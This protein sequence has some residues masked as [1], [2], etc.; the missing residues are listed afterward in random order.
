MTIT[1][2]PPG[3]PLNRWSPTVGDE[4]RALLK[5]IDLA[6]GSSESL[7]R[8]TKSIL[9]KCVPPAAVAERYTGIV[10]GYVQ[11]G[12]TLSFTTLTALARD[13]G[14]RIIVV[15]TG[16][17]ILLFQQS[18][19]RLARDLR[20]T[21]RRD[22]KWQPFAVPPQHPDMS[23]RISDTLDDWLDPITPDAARQTVLITVMKHHSRLDYLASVLRA[24]DLTAVPALIIDDE[25][26]QAGLN[27]AVSRGSQSS[28][29]RALVDLRACCPSHT[30]V[31]Y[32]A[33]P[34]APL[35]INLIDVLS[36]EFAEVISPGS[37]YLG[38]REFFFQHP[39]LV[40]GIP[41]SELPVRGQ[42]IAEPPNSLL[43][44]IRIYFLGVAAGMSEGA[45]GN[46]S[47]LIHPSRTTDFHVDFVEIV[48]AVKEQWRSVLALPPADPD[49][50]ELLEEF[51]S[52]YARL[53]STVGPSIPTF[54]DISIRLP[55][56]I[57]KTQV[58]EVNSREEGS[59]EIDWR[60]DYSWILVGGQSMDRGFT[61]EGLTVTYMPRS[62][63]TANA[64]TV[65]QRARF[66]GYKR[67]YLGY[68]RVYLE[69]V[70]LDAYKK[71]V[72]HEEDLRERLIE[73]TASGKPLSE[74]KRA[75]FLSQVL[76]P[77]R[78]NVMN[79]DYV[80][81]NLSDKWFRVEHP[82]QVPEAVDDN[83]RLV[84]QLAATL[85]FTPD[86]G[87]PQRTTHQQHSVASSV[88]LADLYEGFLTAYRVTEAD[89]SDRFTGARLQIAAYLDE[90]PSSICSVYLMSPNSVRDR[91]VDPRLQIVKLF[92]GEAPVEPRD[93]RGSVYP[94]DDKIRANTG[95]TMQIHRL[96]LFDG[97]GSPLAENV[98]VIALWIPSEMAAAWFV[99]RSP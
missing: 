16:T 67:P 60:R 83:R 99:Q 80:R 63:G 91:T 13:N 98:P 90:H 23:R 62:V 50:V 10:V 78:R 93:L 97:A 38:G 53:A 35:L 48:R 8:E 26:D 64:D 92:Q 32:T 34:Q 36:P 89:E 87:S 88:P 20:L 6:D 73:H 70:A 59:T 24:V 21:T 45:V 75:F 68:C 31:Q 76:R 82:L 71:Y 86:T 2:G 61:V 52:A 43:D 66:F 56:A 74:W 94:G 65:Q 79:L 51:Q 81:D 41:A 30:F 96:N 3:N 29:Y 12:K 39:E 14:Y 54:D 25:A 17:S 7:L 5:H 19:D 49:R 47:M 44:A 55:R 95:L 37:S 46:R 18:T 11:S 58:L 40:E 15:I 27:T 57:R 4:T 22:R 85:P 33:T 1:N 42:P 77:T 28:T 84:D 72:E 69:T 9:A